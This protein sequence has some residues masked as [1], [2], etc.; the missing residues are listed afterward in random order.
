MGGALRV[1][2]PLADL[3]VV[4]ASGD[5]ATRYCGKLFAAHGARVIALY[6]PD[7]RHIGYGGA[8]AA[9]YAAWLDAGK[10]RAAAVPE[11]VAVDL[12]IAG[13]G[14]AEVAAV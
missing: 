2:A 6:V 4:E 3:T 11:D 9:A 10:E 1:S 8:A 14:P 13:Q 5:V 12:V 7:D